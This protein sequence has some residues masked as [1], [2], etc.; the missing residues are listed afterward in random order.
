MATLRKRGQRWHVQIRRK[1]RTSVTRSFRSKLLALAWVREQEFEA[2]Q[3]RPQVRRTL[4]AITVADIVSRDRDEVVPR[5]R[6]AD[7]ETLTLN[8]FMR[9]PLAQV[10]LGDV[11][12]GMVSAYCTERLQ[13]VRPGT[14]NRELDILRHAFAIARRNWDVPLTQN[15]FADVIRPKAAPPRER[16]LHPGEQE[17]LM[18]ACLACRNRF[19]RSLVQFALE[20]GMR[21]GEILRTR[22]CDVSLERRTLH[23][24]MTCCAAHVRL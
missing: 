13:C 9:H 10:A 6:G 18:S 19:M 15:A 17:G 20:T 7:R 4:G 23:I 16:R 2:D 21:R 12:T 3:G 24:P 5:K 14:L 11:T 1:G 22:W 8:A